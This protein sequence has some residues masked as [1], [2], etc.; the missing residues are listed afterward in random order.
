M[1]FR[2]RMPFL[3]LR[4]QH[5]AVSA[6]IHPATSCRAA[7]DSRCPA[8]VSACIGTRAIIHRSRFPSSVDS[9]DTCRPTI[10][11][12]PDR[13]SLLVPRC[14][15]TGRLAARGLPPT[16]RWRR[17]RWAK[18][19]GSEANAGASMAASGRLPLR[20]CPAPPP[21]QAGGSRS[22]SCCCCCSSDGGTPGT[23]R[24]S[25]GG[26]PGSCSSSDDCALMVSSIPAPGASTARLFHAM[27]R[28][29][30]V[31]SACEDRHLLTCRS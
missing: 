15:T 31:P 16:R 7:P 30:R 11:S 21:A 26:T 9:F 29:T 12:A 23:C 22:C 5:V 24:G 1:R 19:A 13:L 28:Q 2:G 25:D 18:L 3:P 17:T 8:C 14:A 20:L 4:Q 27:H 10:R 6:T